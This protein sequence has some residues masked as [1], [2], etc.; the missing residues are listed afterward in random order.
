MKPENFFFVLNEQLKSHADQYEKA[1]EGKVFMGFP[2]FD[3]SSTTVEE[4]HYFIYYLCLFVA[5]DLLVF[6]YENDK[7]LLQ[8]EKLN[9]P[10]FEYGL[11]NIFIYPNQIHERYLQSIRSDILKKTFKLAL[12][13]LILNASE[14]DPKKIFK[15]TLTDKDF[16]KGLFNSLLIKE[17]LS[18]ISNE[19]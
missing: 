8:K 1:S 10:K 15:Y 13:Y 3:F 19:K 7:Y 2:T 5:F 12:E 16:T 9:I 11:T 6:K 14:I 18:S 4:K 17:V